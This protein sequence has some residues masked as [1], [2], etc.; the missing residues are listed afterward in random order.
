MEHK[1]PSP[2][3]KGISVTPIA[4]GILELSMPPVGFISYLVLGETRAALIDTGMGVGSLRAEVEKLTDLPVLVINTHGHPD[5]AG[6]NIEFDETYINPAEY[7]VFERMASLEFRQ[8]DVSHM[9]GGA[10]LM[11]KLQP[12]APLPAPLTDGQRIELGGRALEILYAPGHTHGSI[13]IYDEATGSL[14]AGDNAMRRVSLHEWNSS[15]LPEYVGT[16][17]KLIALAPQRI[18]GGHR[19]NVN[20]P[21]LLDT[22]LR[23]VRRALAGEKGEIRNLR[24]VDAFVLEE[25]GVQFDYTEDHLG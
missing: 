16:L 25:D 20:G 1:Q 6:G 10:E 3:Q 7:D 23:L 18:L 13:C 4:E 24:G 21:E 11:E 22:L 14:F 15:S 2:P 17:E 5:H 19:P 9:P 8:Q 12:T